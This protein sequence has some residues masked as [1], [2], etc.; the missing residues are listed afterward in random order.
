M[1]TSSA[2]DTFSSCTGSSGARGG[3]GSIVCSA[4]MASSGA[5]SAVACKD[6]FIEVR[7]EALTTGKP[8]FLHLRPPPFMT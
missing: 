8:G 4:L 6:M 7:F 5:I 1:I 2:G 3:G